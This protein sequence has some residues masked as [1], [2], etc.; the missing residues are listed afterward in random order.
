MQVDWFNLKRD[1]VDNS[2]VQWVVDKNDVRTSKEEIV[3]AL[4]YRPVYTQWRGEFDS[5]Y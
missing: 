5:I 1:I 4:P 2:W 3:L